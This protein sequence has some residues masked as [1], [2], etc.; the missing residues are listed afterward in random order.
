MSLE[1]FVAEVKLRLKICHVTEN[2]KKSKRQ[3]D[4]KLQLWQKKGRVRE[5]ER[6][7]TKSLAEVF[8]RDVTHLKA[9]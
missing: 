9:A 5:G 4:L 6:L 2:L 1:C 7:M 3:K 8:Y